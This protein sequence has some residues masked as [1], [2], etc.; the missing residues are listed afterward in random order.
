MFLG[1]NRFVNQANVDAGNLGA[2]E[3]TELF[4]QNKAVPVGMQR[5]LAKKGINSSDDFLNRMQ[6]APRVN[7]RK[8]R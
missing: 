8:N 1:R 2:G 4:N 3:N 6:Y 7:F 5:F